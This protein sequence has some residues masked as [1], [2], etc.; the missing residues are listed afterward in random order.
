[1][2]SGRV[3]GNPLLDALMILVAGAL[4]VTPWALVLLLAY[5]LQVLR[6]ALRAGGGRDAR[7]RATF[8]TVAKVPEALGVLEFHLR[9]R[10]G[11]RTALI[12]YK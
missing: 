3:P 8:D 12:E 5:P 10:M 7:L 11:R 2:A 6:Q 9:R 4:L 1:L